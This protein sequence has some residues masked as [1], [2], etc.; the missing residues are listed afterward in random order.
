MYDMKPQKYFDTFE[1]VV[2]EE[3][4]Q[5]CYRTFANDNAQYEDNF[6]SEEYNRCYPLEDAFDEVLATVKTWY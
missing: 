4:L 3:E 1:D 2:I 5:P 6:D